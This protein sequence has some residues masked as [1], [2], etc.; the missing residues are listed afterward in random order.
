[1]VVVIGAEMGVQIGTSMGETV[2]VRIDSELFM[3]EEL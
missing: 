3:Y 1:M 2:H